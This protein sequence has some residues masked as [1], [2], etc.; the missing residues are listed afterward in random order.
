MIK[1]PKEVAKIM[2]TL[3]DAKQEAFAVGD[4]VR[5]AL[6]G[7]KPVGWDIATD[8]PLDK[9]KELFPEAQVHSQKYSILRM[10]FIE[11]HYDDEG[12]FAGEDGIIVDI[13]TY[14][15]GGL[16]FSDKIEDDIARRAFTVNAIADN[17]YKIVD[18]YNGR[19]DIK[20][21][22]IRTTRPAEELFREDPI[23]MMKAIHYAAELDF[24]LTKDVFEAIAGNYQLLESVSVDKIRDEFTETITASHGGKGLSLIMDTG[25]LNILLGAD[26]VARLSNREKSD[27]VILSQNID[28]TYQ[29]PERRLGL[30]YTC[31]SRKKAT[32]S[33][34]KLN[35]DS[36]TYQHLTD[37]VRDMAKLYFTAQPEE[38]KRFIYER[39][40]DRYQYLANLE[41]AQ[42]IVFDYH[43]DTKIKSKMYM[44][45]EFKRK[46][47]AVFVEDLAIDANDLIEAGICTT[48]N[49]GK[50]LSMLV[51]TIH[52][53][54]NLNDY[55]E[56]L[57]LAKKY[58]KSKLAA[59]TRGVK[60]LR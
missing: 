34:E 18:P 33:I 42:R 23:Q 12:K 41:K 49:A 51:E 5:D 57:K 13:G 43:S 20:K 2:K 60:W 38:L 8:A 56:L 45:D 37:A 1:L 47:E 26:V 28:K 22:L 9:L 17:P 3:T 54:P 30:F 40:W 53:K 16:N 25:I 10:E 27:L 46:G 52:V 24:D 32:P 15:R 6:L 50:M 11:E 14:R 59:M 29:V 58:K 19:E 39:G 35:F 36:A 55:K 4:C 7:R 48:D 31:V 21:K 44:I